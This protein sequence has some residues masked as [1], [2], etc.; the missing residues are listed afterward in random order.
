[1]HIA[2]SGLK[3]FLIISLGLIFLLGQGWLAVGPILHGSL[4]FTSDVKSTV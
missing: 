4:I 2:L 3:L 1:L